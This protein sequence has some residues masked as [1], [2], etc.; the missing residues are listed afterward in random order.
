MM[1]RPNRTTPTK[2][3]AAKAM[4]STRRFV[5]VV[6][7]TLFITSSAFSQWEWAGGFHSCDFSSVCSAGNWIF[8][9]GLYAGDQM[10][11]SPDAGESWKSSSHI[12]TGTRHFTLA[13]DPADTVLFA[14][15]LEQDHCIA[16]PGRDLGGERFRNRSAHRGGP[17]VFPG[18]RIP[19]QRHPHGCGH[20]GGD[21]RLH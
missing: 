9:D 12:G 8:M 19:R 10:A 11:Y 6:S 20:V 4:T 13:T 18:G 14:T 17:G 3:N 15:M 2:Q 16:R 7:I 5:F 1:Y 21:V